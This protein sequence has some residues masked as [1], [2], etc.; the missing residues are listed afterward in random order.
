MKK[1]KLRLRAFSLKSALKYCALAICFALLNF[2][3]PFREPLA[4]ALFY[5]SLICGF[6]PLLAGAAYL[7]AAIVPLSAYAFLSAAIQALFL[8][9]LSVAYRRANRRMGIERLLYIAAA[10]LPFIFLFPHAGYAF[11]LSALWQKTV[12][13]VFVFLLSVLFEGGLYALLFRAFKSRLS[14]TQLTELCLIWLFTGTG[15]CTALGVPAFYAVSLALL[16]LSVLLLKNAA[17]VPFSVALSLPLCIVRGSATPIAE[18]AAF[19]CFVL[20]LSPYGKHASSLALLLAFLAAQFFEGLYDATA[21]EI[22]FTLASCAIPAVA[23]CCLPEKLFSRAGHGLLYYRNN[24]PRVAVNRNRRAVGERLYEVSALFREIEGAFAEPQEQKNY[25]ALIAERLRATLCDGCPSLTKCK[26]AGV[27]AGMEKLAAIGCAKGQVSL[28]DLT[29][30]LSASC[31]NAA[32]LLF[33]CN[34]LLAGYRNN[35]REME[36]ARESRRLLAEQAHGVSEILRDIALEQSE[37]YSF[38]EGENALS[39]ALSSAGILSSEIF[40]YGDGTSLTVSM[41]LAANV[42]CKKLCAVAGEALGVPLSL[43]EKIPLS[44]SH[45]CY[46]L[47]RKPEFDAAFGIAFRCKEGET[48]CGDTY[49]MLKIDERRFLVALSDGM[50]SGERARNVS[51]KTLSLLESFYKAKMPSETV[52]DTVNRLISYSADEMFSCLDLA[53]VNLDTG[54]A[55]VVKIG[56]PVGFILSPEE[57]R[58][59]EGESLPMGALDAVHPATLRAQMNEN[60]FMLFMSD[61]VTSAFSSSAELYSYLSGLSP[62]NPQSLAEEILN[63]ALARTNGI[64]YDD[65]TVLAVKLMKT[66]VPA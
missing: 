5:A 21:R 33:A 63:R 50:G 6:H 34:K 59:L 61:G 20:L 14:A 3:M 62:V 55:D 25:S 56:S 24:L 23:V 4:F 52:L 11:P 18:Y 42:N 65:M 13:S 66:A 7:I 45:T 48:A 22:L 58:V 12:L 41:T 43:S 54:A 15:L 29:A 53:A 38:S 40:V 2:A 31:K 36:S 44:D 39:R 16:L 49:S 1:P 28:V 35:L 51:D 57:L 46:V 9:A 27:F 26:N 30:E 47:K 37:E 60:D 8:I 10:Q 19:S 32:G 17:A 64:A